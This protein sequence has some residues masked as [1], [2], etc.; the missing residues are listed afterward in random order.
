MFA[1]ELHKIRSAQLIR[2]ADDYRLVRTAQRRR[3]SAD[4]AARQT[5]SHS[6]RRGRSVFTRAA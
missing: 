6:S 4:H 3:R 1:Y 2:E 5:R